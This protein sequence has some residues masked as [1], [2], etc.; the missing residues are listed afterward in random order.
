VHLEG[1]RAVCAAQLLATHELLPVVLGRR[2]WSGATIVTVLREPVSRVWSFYKYIRRKSIDFQE[3]PLLWFLER[4]HNMTLPQRTK[5]NALSLSANSSRSFGASYEY[6]MPFS[7]HW[8]WQLSNAMT[9]Q[10]S[11]TSRQRTALNDP[12]A[13]PSSAGASK[14]LERAK[15][16]LVSSVDIVGVTEDMNGFELMLAAR[17]PSFFGQPGC[18]IP[19]GSS[20]INLS[21]KRVTKGDA[22]DV[23]DDVTRAQIQRLNDL[24]ISLYALAHK[25][26][27]IQKTCVDIKPK[28]QDERLFACLREA[29]IRAS[30]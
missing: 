13:V 14:A 25:V 10:F 9:F 28:L 18:R 19:S 22:P 29:R 23:L 30:R 2:Y 5:Q 20:A 8:H 12:T 3:R 1:N 24:D 26:Y 15:S 11:A 7:P 6:R 27:S 16:A 21:S 17:W 4:W